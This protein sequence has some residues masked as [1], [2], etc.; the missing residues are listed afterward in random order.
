MR[1]STPKILVS[2][3]GFKL[4]FSKNGN[5]YIKNPNRKIMVK[6]LKTFFKN[7]ELATFWYFFMLKLIAF[8]TTNKKVGNTRS[9]NVNPFQTAC[10]K[11]PK[12]VSPFPGEFTMI[13]KATSMPLKTSNERYLFFN[14]FMLVGLVLVR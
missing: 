11:M 13:I 10:F 3:I 6:R 2:A 1:C 7:S 5:Q 8:P 4:P 9:V 12:L 14:V